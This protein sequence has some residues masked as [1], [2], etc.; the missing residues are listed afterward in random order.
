[1]R[2]V[3]ELRCFDLELGG[4]SVFLIPLIGMSD[5][6][7]MPQVYTFNDIAHAILYNRL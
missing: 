1:M 4:D 7:A 6:D 2:A 3:G 5:Q